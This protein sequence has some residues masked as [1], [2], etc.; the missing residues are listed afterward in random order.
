MAQHDVNFC[1]PIPQQL[2]NEAGKARSIHDAFFVAAGGRRAL[3]LPAL[4]PFYHRGRL[5]R[6]THYGAHPTRLG[7]C[8]LR[9]VRQDRRRRPRSSQAS[10][11][12]SKPSTVHLCTEIGFV[13]T[14]P[15]FQRTH[16]TSNAA[17]LLLRFALEPPAAGGL[18]LRRVA[19]TAN[20]HNAGSIRGSGAPRVPQGG[21]YCAGERVLPTSRTED[22]GN[23]GGARAGDPNHG[24]LGRDTLLLSLC[25][26]DWEGGAREAVNAIMQRG[27]SK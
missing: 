4:G 8:A 5:C 7:Q 10:S 18:G 15:R 24:C 9:R 2:E 27:L 21:R 25:W 22:V 20:I 17:G 19:W 3:Q 26:D 14:L 1:F 23:G 12:S 13:I 16:V 6:H 11:A